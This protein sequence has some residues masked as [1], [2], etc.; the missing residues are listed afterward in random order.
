MQSELIAL[1]LV[2]LRKCLLETVCSVSMRA[3]SKLFLSLLFQSPNHWGS[4]SAS[5]PLQV[6]LVKTF[7]THQPQVQ[8]VNALATSSWPLTIVIWRSQRR[9]VTR[10]SELI[11]NFSRVH[12]IRQRFFQYLPTHK[13]NDPSKL[14]KLSAFSFSSPPKCMSVLKCICAVRAP[15]LNLCWV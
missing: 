2:Y 10:F 15:R 11:L 7:T 1:V 14:T 5:L 9:P 8:N 3:K 13:F 12:P 4:L 6:S